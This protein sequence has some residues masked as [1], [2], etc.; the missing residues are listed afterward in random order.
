MPGPLSTTRTVKY[1]LVYAV[2]IR[3]QPPAG[4]ILNGIA[5]QINQ[6]LF[7]CFPIHLNGRHIPGGTLDHHLAFGQLRQERS[8]YVVDQD[9]ILSIRVVRNGR[10]LPLRAN[11]STFSISVPKRH[12]FV[13][14]DGQSI[15]LAIDTKIAMSLQF[16]QREIGI[17]AN[18]WSVAF[19]VHVIL[20]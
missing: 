2:S 11:V 8:E 19:A 13:L 18:V 4:C 10:G 9:S 16:M 12:C 20:D 14:N 17:H 5:D 15:Q 6:D 1:S 7:K 3:S